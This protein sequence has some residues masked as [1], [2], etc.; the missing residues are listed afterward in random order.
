MYKTWRF[1]EKII[2]KYKKNT[3]QN[4]IKDQMLLKMNRLVYLS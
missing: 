4:R 3:L 1:K 2:F